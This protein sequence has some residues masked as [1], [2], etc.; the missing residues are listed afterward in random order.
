M[1]KAGQS[2]AAGPLFSLLTGCPNKVFVVSGNQLFWV[3]SILVTLQIINKI[4]LKLFVYTAANSSSYACYIYF[5]IQ[6]TPQYSKNTYTAEVP[7]WFTKQSGLWLLNHVRNSSWLISPFA[8]F[9]FCTLC[10]TITGG[11]H[12]HVPLPRCLKLRLH[13]YGLWYM[14]KSFI[15]TIC[16][17]LTIWQ[18]KSLY[19]TSSVI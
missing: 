1:T 9:F 14:V 17:N 19:S 10:K 7:L 2:R 4:S 11:W 12:L 15:R 16:L 13:V 18:F 8:F 3:L 5:W 6:F